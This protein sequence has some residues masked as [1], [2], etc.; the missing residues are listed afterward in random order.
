LLATPIAI[1]GILRSGAIIHILY[2][3][4]F[5][6][7][8]PVLAVFFVIFW[9]VS[10]AI[11]YHNIL[12]S[13]EKHH[14]FVWLSPINNLVFAAAL[15]L[16]THQRFH[17]GAVGAAAS[18]AIPQFVVLPF[19][20][21]RTKK[22]FDIG[23]P[24]HFFSYLAAGFL[25][26]VSGGPFFWQSSVLFQILGS[27]VGAS[28]Y[29]GFLYARKLIGPDDIAYIAHTCNPSNMFRYFKQDFRS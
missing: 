8:A 21:A 7:S 14:V 24:D 2:G 1:F 25:M 6:G 12:Y 19:I 29:L 17:F 4:S 5:S 28:A 18:F 15:W 16:L 9:F 10:F 27:L 11:P 13:T 22:I 3:P 26:W 23:L 20:M